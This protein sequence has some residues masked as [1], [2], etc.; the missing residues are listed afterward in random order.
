M[1]T[2]PPRADIDQ[3][4]RTAKDR[5]RAARAGDADAAASITSLRGRLTLADAQLQLARDHGF[6]SWPALQIEVARRRVLDLRD[7]DAIAAFLVEHPDA[8][9][10]EMREWLDHPRG[11]SPLGYVAMARY[12]TAAGRW[13]NVTGTAAAAHLLIANGAHVEGLPG[14]RETPLI[15][16]A[17]YGDADV[18]AVLIAAGADIDAVAAADAGGVTGGSALLH[19]AVFGMTDV[20]DVLVAAGA[21]VR[22]IAEAAATGEIA[23][24]LTPGTPALDKLLALV[25]A[26]DHER[27][28]VIDALVAAGTPFDD[29]DPIYHRHPLRLA[30]AN[31]RSRSVET[32]LARGADPDARDAR[33]MTALDHCRRARAS[34]ADTTGHDTVEALL[35]AATAS[36]AN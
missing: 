13:R 12:D 22:S 24:W 29:E 14:D 19:A 17:S 1:P 26:A 25:M 23:G 18:A 33:G 2:L 34:A 6:A 27:I 10:A 28:E 15:T 31:G 4:R 9:T 16:A 20:V 36:S 35:V 32:L 11:A 3:L 5:L 30:A 8:A 7:A 21:R